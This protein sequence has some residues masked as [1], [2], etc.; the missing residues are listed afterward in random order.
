MPL[1]ESKQSENLRNS[2]EERNEV[3]EPHRQEVVVDRHGVR[4]WKGLLKVKWC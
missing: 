1:I 2:V 3:V 4:D